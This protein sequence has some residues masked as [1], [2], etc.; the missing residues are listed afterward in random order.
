MDWWHSYFYGVDLTPH[1]FLFVTPPQSHTAAPLLPLILPFFFISS[2][3][4]P[5]KSSLN[6]SKNPCLH[7]LKTLVTTYYSIIYHTTWHVE[8]FVKS[9]SS[10]KSHHCKQPII[11]LFQNLHYMICLKCFIEEGLDVAKP[12]WTHERMILLL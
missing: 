5:F 6:Q 9:T 11:S 7:E 4:D 1:F 2:Q 12:I 8:S 3:L 10:T